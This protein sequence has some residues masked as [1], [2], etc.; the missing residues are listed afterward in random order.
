MERE[1]PQV[2]SHDVLTCFF[3]DRSADDER[4]LCELRVRPLWQPAVEMQYVCHIDCLRKSAPTRRIR[5]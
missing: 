2:V 3:C 5:A 4:F 1:T